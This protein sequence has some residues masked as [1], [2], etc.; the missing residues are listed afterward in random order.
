MQCH[1]PLIS[2]GGK[3]GRS[4]SGGEGWWGEG[5]GERGRD[6][7]GREVMYERKIKRKIIW[8]KM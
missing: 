6:G 8:T 5:L 3:S 1:V 7:C 2:L 4:G